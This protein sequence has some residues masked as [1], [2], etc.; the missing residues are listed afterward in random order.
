MLKITLPLQYLSILVIIFILTSVLTF[1][2]IFKI[3]THIPGF[4]STD[5]SYGLLWDSWRI[6]YAFWHKLSLTQTFFIAYPFGI[7]IYVTGYFSSLWLLLHHLLSIFTSLVFTYN[8]QVIINLSLSAFFTYHLVYYLTKNNYSALMSSIIFAYCPYQFMRIWQHLGL[9]YNQWLPLVLFSVILIKEKYSRK[10]AVLL[11]FSFLLTFS[12]DWSI[13]YFAVVILASFF[14]YIL[15]YDF[16]K[17]FFGKQ[18]YLLADNFIYFKR[19]FFI[20]LITFFI[21]FGQFLRLIIYKLKAPAQLESSVFNVYRRPFEDLFSQSARPLSYFLPA[22]SH[23]VFGKFTEN[24]VGTFFYGDSFTEH[25]LYLGWTTL[26]LAFVAFRKWKQRHKKLAVVSCQLSGSSELQ[27]NFYISFFIFLA[28]ISWLF[29]QPPW[30]KIGPIKIYMPS[31]FMYNIL[32]MYRAYCRFGIV[33]MLSTTVLAGFGLKFIF[34]KFKTNISK[35]SVTLLF[36]SLIL[37]EFWNYPSFRVIDVSRMP[38]VYYWL[39]EQ[40]E[41]FVIAEYPLDADSPNEIYKFYQTYHEK[42]LIN[43]TI[44]G[45]YANRIANTITKLSDLHTVGVLKWMQVKYV[46]VHHDG[47]LQTDLIEDREELN[48]ISENQ[49]LKFIRNFPPQKCLN[50]NIMCVQKTGPIDIYEVITSPIKPEIE[51]KCIF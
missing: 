37:F 14:I 4:F 51:E 11:F 1:P 7:N 31:F 45:T 44:S 27:D 42:K 30:W 47:Y 50:E 8:L 16:R 19:V 41:G 3:T 22:V 25:T 9:S 17:K 18:R 35:A 12:F 24:F 36:S 32:P 38:Q 26:L 5:E 6:K 49:G 13:M 21:L 10:N 20:G 15:F 48:R 46:L 28:I 39:K 34:E 40:P 43:G 2:L 33:V 23:P 29:S